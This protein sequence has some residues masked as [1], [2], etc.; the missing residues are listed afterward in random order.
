[1]DTEKQWKYRTYVLSDLLKKIEFS[2]GKE[3]YST[4]EFLNINI[5]LKDTNLRFPLRY[6]ISRDY[7]EIQYVHDVWDQ[8][9]VIF[10]LNFKK[11][12]MEIYG[13]LDDEMEMMWEVFST[14]V[15]SYVHTHIKA[16]YFYEVCFKHPKF[17][18]TDKIMEMV[19]KHT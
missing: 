5:T 3:T 16:S 19:D 7:N 1:V 14:R 13:L 10:Y 18:D 15:N 9:F 8:D 17:P 11:H 12:Y 2:C 4:M 6:R